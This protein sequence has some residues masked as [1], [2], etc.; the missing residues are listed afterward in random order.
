MHGHVLSPSLHFLSGMDANRFKGLNSIGNLVALATLQ[1]QRVA[2][3]R[4][5]I[6]G[7]AQPG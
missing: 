2:L 1:P 4:Q 5:A 3:R 7:A 6:C